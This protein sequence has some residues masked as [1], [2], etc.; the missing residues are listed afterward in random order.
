GAAPAVQQEAP[1]ISLDHRASLAALFKL[2][3]V[4]DAQGVFGTGDVY[5]GLF[6]FQGAPQ[7][8]RMFRKPHR[9]RIH[10]E[11][12]SEPG[13]LLIRQSTSDGVIAVDAEGN[14]RSVGE[15]FIL[16]HWAGEMSWVYPYEQ[17]NRRLS[18]GMRGQGVLRV[19][20]ML[21]DMGYAVRPTGHFDGTTVKEVKRFQRI[22]GLEVN[23][24][25]GTQTKAL[26]YQMSG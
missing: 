23:G 9:L 17:E 1:S 15:G 3:N 26:L 24:I 22:L 19:Q 14:E 8:Y 13:Y 25:V 12:G 20:E 18:E 10:T 11:S 2:F 4:K 16:A 21:Q 6:S 7:L 5:P